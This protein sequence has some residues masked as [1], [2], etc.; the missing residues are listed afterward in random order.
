MTTP[1][2]APP[3]S[4][5]PPHAIGPSA[6]WDRLE[7]RAGILRRLRDF[8]HKEGFLEVETPAISR[9][10]VAE[11]HLRPWTAAPLNGSARAAS[12]P[13]WL[14]PSPEAHMKRLLASGAKSIYQ[15]CRAFRADEAGKYHN[16]EFTML[17]WYRVGETYDSCLRFTERLCERL[18]GRGPAERLSYAAAFE[19]YVGLNPHAAGVD[20]L[21]AAAVSRDISVPPKLDAADRDLWLNLLLAEAVEPRLGIAGPTLL[22]DYPA[23]Q[24]ALAAT[25]RVNGD[26]G[27]F[28]VAERFE[29]YVDG[30]ELANG[31]HELLDANVLRTRL[32]RVSDS[33]VADGGSPL[34]IPE[35]LLQAMDNG[36]P[37]CCGVALGFDRLVMLAV[38]ANSLAEV[39]AF[40]WDRA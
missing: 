36:L 22:H 35:Y 39:M 37:D 2:N 33:R 11:R 21:R 32:E 10:I 27:S 30:V 16:P 6:N 31:Y 1:R 18:L 23:S 19:R 7:Q 8:F 24:A 17:E 15:V 38:G 40:P 3:D 26:R 28:E 4:M 5:S 9:E 13:W 12:S 25:R 34:P 29:V 14:Q 20:E